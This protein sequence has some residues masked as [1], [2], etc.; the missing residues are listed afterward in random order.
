MQPKLLPKLELYEDSLE[1]H[2]KQFGNETKH[3]L[4]WECILGW[5]CDDEL[6]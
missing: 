4:Q 3:Y 2:E 6:Y 5:C 1:M